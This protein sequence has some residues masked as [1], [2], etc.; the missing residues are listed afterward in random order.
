MIL[1]TNFLNLPFKENIDIYS[2]IDDLI[3][4]PEIIVP[5]IV[6][7]ELKGAK[8]KYWR[9]S[10]ELLKAKD[11]KIVEIEVKESV[12]ETLLRHCKRED[13]YLVT[14]DEE[15]KN[16]ALKKGVQIISIRNKQLKVFKK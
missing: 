14:L 2:Q 11:V 8:P 12:D 6:I 9:V 10:I 16:K 5:Q 4:N 3:N 7:D 1:D 13:A 15:L